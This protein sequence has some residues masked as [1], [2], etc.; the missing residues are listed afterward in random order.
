M[1]DDALKSAREQFFEGAGPL[2][3]TTATCRQRSKPK[4]QGPLLLSASDRLH[5][6]D[7]RLRRVVVR[8]CRNSYAAAKVVELFE[9]CVVSVFRGDGDWVLV[10]PVASVADETT[11]LD[12]DNNNNNTWWKDLLLQSPT[13]DTNNGTGDYRAQFYFH[14]T[15]PTGGFHRLLLQAVCQFHGLHTVSRMVYDVVQM[16]SGS[17]SKA[18]ALTVTGARMT[19]EPRFRLLEHLGQQEEESSS[20]Q[21]SDAKVTQVSNELSALVV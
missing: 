9:E 8:A 2:P 14:P 12:G 10:T 1:Q 3:T 17:R 20:R 15:S 16:E 18:R 11:A 7:P 19:E 6:V 13:V 21:Q 4:E 5:R